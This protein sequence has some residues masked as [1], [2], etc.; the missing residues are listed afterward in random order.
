MK[1]IILTI[2]ACFTISMAAQAQLTI[3]LKA[4]AGASNVDV[5]EV[6]SNPWQ[7]SNSD[8]TTGYHAGI[9]TRLQLLGLF[10]QPEAV[11]ASTGGKV[12]I[13]DEQ[14]TE[15]SIKNF[16]FTR[17][18]VPMLAGISF[19]RVARIQ[20]GPVA[21]VLLSAHQDGKAIDD[22]LNETD[23]G[24][25]AGVGVDISRL[26]LDLRYERVNRNYTSEQQS[27]SRITNNQILLSAGYKLFQ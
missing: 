9:F 6:R 23:W 16:R 19:F 7:L 10:V 13:Y 26:T 1:H 22:Y 2:L 20:A 8:N 18:D 12:E 4:G 14:T 5:N 3:G 21:S 24:W 25:Q 15:S 27:S 17:L 11:L